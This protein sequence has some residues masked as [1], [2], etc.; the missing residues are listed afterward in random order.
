MTLNKLWKVLSHSTWAHRGDALL[1]MAATFLGGLLPLWGGLFIFVVVDAEVNFLQRFVSHGEF[2]LYAAGLLSNSIYLTIRIW[3]MNRLAFGWI[4]FA[5]IALLVLCTI[6]FVLTVLSASDIGAVRIN[7]TW[8][9]WCSLLVFGLS[10]LVNGLY[11][12]FN[13]AMESLDPNEAEGAMQTAFDE[14]F[15]RMGEANGK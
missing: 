7:I 9:A 12:L 2:A 4:L 5:I 10:V 6:M 8:I 1:S 15:E 11:A 3:I 13:N 14:A